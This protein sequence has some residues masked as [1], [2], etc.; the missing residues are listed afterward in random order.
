MAGKAR[1][2]KIDGSDEN[3]P[4]NRKSF[5]NQMNTPVNGDL[6]QR[7]YQPRNV[8]DSKVN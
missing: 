2:A 5:Q 3:S 6:N 8:K 7:I 4:G 1:C